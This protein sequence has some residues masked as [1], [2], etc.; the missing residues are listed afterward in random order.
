MNVTLSFDVSR[1]KA[2]L[3]ALPSGLSEGKLYQI[4]HDALRVGPDIRVA[5]DAAADGALQLIVPLWLDVGKQFRQSESMSKQL[6]DFINKVT[7][8]AEP[9][10]PDPAESQPEA[11]QAAPA[12]LVSVQ[13]LRTG[14]PAEGEA[15]AADCPIFVLPE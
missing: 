15:S 12:K 8:P 4:V 1:L 13:L 6:R 11:A 7:I 3:A 10:S 9:N 5:T 2:D 14:G